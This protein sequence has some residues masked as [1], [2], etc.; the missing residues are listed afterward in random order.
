M[1]GVV[2]GHSYRGHGEQRQRK[3]YQKV[4]GVG[5]HRRCSVYPNDTALMAKVRNVKEQGT[6]TCQGWPHDTALKA[7]VRNVRE[8]GTTTYQVWPNDTALKAK[9]RNIRKQGTR[10]Y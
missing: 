9:V 5:T 6:T 10:R 8:Q 2:K 1:P 4:L 3:M 7:N